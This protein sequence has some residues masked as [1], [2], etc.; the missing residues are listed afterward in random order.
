MYSAI[1]AAVISVVIA[2]LPALAAEHVVSKGGVIQEAIKAAAPG[3]TI[4]VEP[5]IYKEALHIDKPDIKLIGKI[6]GKDWPILDG[7]GK[8]NDGIIASGSGFKIENFH[9]RRYRANGVTTQAAN[10]VEIRH[11]LVENTGIYGIYP[12][13]GTNI[14]IEDTVTW[15]IADA[16]IY[17][18]MC[19]HVDVRRNEVFKN[20]AG[21]EAENSHHVLIENNSVYDNSAGILVFTLPELPRKTS[22]NIIVRRNFI[23][24]NNH[25]NFGAP[26]SIVAA[27]PPGSGVIVLAA[28]QVKFEDN[29]IRQN[30]FGG[31]V[32]A[33]HSTIP[34]MAVDPQVEPNSDHVMVLRNFYHDNARKNLLNLLVWGR[35][36][37][38]HVLSGSAPEGASDILPKGADIIATKK[39]VGNCLLDR[40]TMTTLDAEHLEDCSPDASTRAVTT[41]LIPSTSAQQFGSGDLGE[42]TYAAVCAGCHAMNYQLIG[43]PVKEIQQKYAGNAAGI[44]GFANNPK[45][46]RRNFPPMPPQSY[47]GDDKLKA[48]AHYMLKMK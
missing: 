36:L 45:A 6:V 48:V 19:H 34:N 39:G 10:N 8:L 20:V 37:L 1:V 35:F 15:G 14:L 27:V 9:I 5:G 2:T 12:T 21:I 42:Q 33:D 47:L 4:I 7:E 22:E 13:L 18:G 16:G 17:I 43:P 23:F 11:L 26:G 28:D 40:T 3:D 24:D 38:K 29:I 31:I 30:S 44:V 25:H 41:M 46:V 32:I